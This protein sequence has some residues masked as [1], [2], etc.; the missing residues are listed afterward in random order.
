MPASRR[1]LIAGNWKMYKNREEAASFVEALRPFVDGFSGEV[2]LAVPFTA[3]EAVSSAA[4]GRIRVGAQNMNDATEGAFTGE[5]A[6]EM[7]TDVGAQFVLLG[8]SERRHIFGE[9]NDFINRKVLRSLEAGLEPIVCFGETLEQREA[10]E[11]AQVLEQQFSE[12]LASVT[13]EQASKLVIAYEPVWA[14][15]TGMTA[16]PGDAQKAHQQLRGLLEQHF[17]P[18]AA[19]TVPILYGG[20]VKPSNAAELMAQPDV[21]GVLVGGAS[22]NAEQFGGII[23]CDRAPAT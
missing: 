16:T 12:T 19:S 6:G 1:R 15:G 2:Y 17:G 13:P 22:L 4:E 11:T 8:H 3:I 20:S 21:D 23:N 14:I 9:Q 18:Q 7:L 10:G 5:I